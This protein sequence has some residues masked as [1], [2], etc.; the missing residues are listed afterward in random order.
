VSSHAPLSALA[1]ALHRFEPPWIEVGR[2]Y[3]RICFLRSE[4]LA[5]EADAI[6]RTEYADV[7]AKAREASASEYEADAIL[8]ALRSEEEERVSSAIAFAEVLVPMLA[9][10]LS[11]FSPAPPAAPA[12]RKARSPGHDEPRGIADFID[13]MLA[14]ERAGTR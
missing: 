5:N 13:D 8:K 9:K 10:R 11:P 7:A 4:G 3:R 14:Q 1:E 6:E 12:P 2:V